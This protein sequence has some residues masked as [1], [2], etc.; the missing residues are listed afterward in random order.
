[1]RTKNTSR[2]I[3]TALL[4]LVS[5]TVAGLASAAVVRVLYAVPSEAVD[6]DHPAPK[7]LGGGK[8]K[9]APQRP[10]QTATSGFVPSAPSST[11]VTGLFGL[12]FSWPINPL[13]M[14]LL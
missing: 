5:L 8:G 10:P 3:I 7:D 13:H 1:M 12:P 14:A 11:S 9:P 4:I 2:R 6:T